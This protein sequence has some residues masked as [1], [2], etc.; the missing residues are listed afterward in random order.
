MKELEDNTK[1]HKLFDPVKAKAQVDVYK[2]IYNLMDEED[3]ELKK[4]PSA[5]SDKERQK[6]QDYFNQDN[7]SEVDK[8]ELSK[9]LERL[10]LEIDSLEEV[11]STHQ[12]FKFLRTTTS[13][14]VFENAL[15]EKKFDEKFLKNQKNM[16]G[17]KPK[18][19]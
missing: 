10:Q 9:E 19:V 7:L 2:E 11:K 18:T 15:Y 3:S 5:V 12:G 8:A 16:V 1:E 4:L 6:I 13:K 17:D 14:D